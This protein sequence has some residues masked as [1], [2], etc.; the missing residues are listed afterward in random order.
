ML[1][2][3]RTLLAS[4]AFCLGLAMSS[5]NAAET[6]SANFLFACDGTNKLVTLTLG[7]LGVSTTRFIQHAE[8][9]LFENNGG[10]QYIIV[11]ADPVKQLASL[12]KGDVSRTHAFIASLV[13]V[14]TTAA[15]TITI[16]INGAC[17]PGAGQIQGL[18]TLD[19]FS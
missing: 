11:N 7:S 10:L 16:T 17:N 1:G 3:V 9:I 8:V 15:G 6:R 18:L 13:P 12:G 5:A 14:P 4:S 2:R 19:F